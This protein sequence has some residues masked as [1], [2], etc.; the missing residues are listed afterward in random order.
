MAKINIAN[1]KKTIYYLQRNGLKSTYSAVKERMDKKQE[2]PYVFQPASKEE[3]EKQHTLATSFFSTRFSIV[4]PTYRT[5]E[6]YLREMIDSCLEQTYPNW[7]L[8]LADA[9]PEDSV[10]S[11]VKTYADAR[12]KYVKLQSN[13]GIAEN[14]NRGLEKATG[15]YVGLLDHDDVLEPNA[16]YEVVKVIEDGQ[17][18]G[19]DVQM[20]YSDED[21]CNGDR[22]RYYEPNNKEDFNFD[23]L[24]S[25]NYLSFSGFKS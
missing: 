8:I 16:L 15:A 3:L 6:E 24:L 12:I 14:T 25:N 11:I 5:K 2:I 19:I 7:E 21:K 9:T 20:I 23:L 10:E 4:V 17:N 13:D 1:I 18:V 22:T